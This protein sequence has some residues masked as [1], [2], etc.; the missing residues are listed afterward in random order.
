VTPDIGPWVGGTTITVSGSGFTGTTGVAVG[1]LN[2]SSVQVI[3]DSTLTCV[4]PARP[5]WASAAAY[6]RVTTPVGTNSATASS[7]FTYVQPLVATW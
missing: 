1:G 2:A 6:V 4:T 3:N 7:L 5:L